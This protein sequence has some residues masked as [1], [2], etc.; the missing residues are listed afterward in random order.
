M[1]GAMDRAE[2]Y[3]AKAR[4]A[5]DIAART[6]DSQIR[7]SWIRIAE[8]YRELASYLLKPK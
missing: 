8:G 2:N 5:E 7:Q 6:I 3:L 1:N 4:E